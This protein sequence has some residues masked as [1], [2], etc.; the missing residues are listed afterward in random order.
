MNLLVC[1]LNSIYSHMHTYIIMH[2]LMKQEKDEVFSMLVPN[3]LCKSLGQWGIITFVFS[4]YTMKLFF[5]AF[6]SFAGNHEFQ[7]GEYRSIRITKKFHTLQGS[8][9][10]I[11]IYITMILK[12]AFVQ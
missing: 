9:F 4:V 10:D 8:S 1:L 11:D 2:V 5:V 6:L 7:H 3:F 12:F